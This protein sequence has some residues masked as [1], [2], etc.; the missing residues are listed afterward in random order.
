MNRPRHHFFMRL[1]M[2]DPELIKFSQLAGILSLGIFLFMGLL[3][4]LHSQNV[5]LATLEEKYARI[6]EQNRALQE[7]NKELH[8]LNAALLPSEPN[9]QRG[10]DWE[11]LRFL[12]FEKFQLVQPH[13]AIVYLKEFE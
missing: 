12:S 8:R 1:W 13:E 9:S 10:L 4:M 11:T 7:T 6:K 2:R 3:I 5:Y